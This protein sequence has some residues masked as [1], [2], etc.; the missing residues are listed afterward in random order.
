MNSV[1]YLIYV[2]SGAYYYY[3]TEDGKNY[4]QTMLDVRDY[5]HTKNI[6][7]K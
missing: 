4:E 2:Y 5:A 6:P 3:N 7:Y 1:C